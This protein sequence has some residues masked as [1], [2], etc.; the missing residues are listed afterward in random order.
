MSQL[1]TLNID[2]RKVTVPD[3]ITIIEAA[4]HAGIDI[5]H[6]CYCKGLESTE[7]CRL[8]LVELEGAKE[9][10]VSCRRKVKSG[11]V[12]RTRTDRVLEARRFVVLTTSDIEP[13][14]KTRKIQLSAVAISQLD[15]VGEVTNE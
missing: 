3:G 2:G 11:M 9:L 12:V 13:A 15:E 6:L 1:A 7:A 10:V 8:C 5:P 4:T 14:T